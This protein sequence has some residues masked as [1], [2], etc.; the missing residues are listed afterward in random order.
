MNAVALANAY[1]EAWNARN[2]AAIVATF[3]ERGTYADPTTNGPLSG[4]AIGAYAS[5]L[6]QAFPDLA[7]EIRSAAQTAASTVVAEWTMRGT[8]TGSFAGLP[9]TGRAVTLAGVDVIETDAGGLRSVTGYFDS[10]LVPKQLGLQVLVQP[11]V[12]GPFAFG[13]SV[14]VQSGK[15]TLPGAFSITTIWNDSSRDAEIRERSAATAREM[16]PMEGFIG[17]TLARAGGR[18]ITITAWEKPEHAKQMMRSPSHREAMAKFWSELGDAGFTSVWTPA[19]INPL[20][21]RC[22]AC[23]KMNDSAKAAGK[24]GCGAALPEPPAFF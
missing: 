20:W 12:I 11:H 2:A 18:G 16:L 10:A 8:N 9:P 14:T 5:G 3:V 19:Y 23:R 7:F 17:L 15:K 22:P 21:V 6:W 13:N 24:C 1:F 4:A